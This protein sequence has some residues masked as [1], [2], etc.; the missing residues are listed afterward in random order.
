VQIQVEAV[1]QMLAGSFL[2]RPPAA[3]W[4]ELAAMLALGLA[5]VALAIR[6][7]PVWAA[8]V[9]FGLVLC[10][11]AAAATVF[12][13]AGLLIDPVGPAAATIVAANVAGL[14]SFMRT[15]ALKT[16]IQSKFERYVPPE[17]VA[18]LLREPQSLKLDGEL[19]EVTALIC[20][21]EEFSLLTEKSEP[22]A[23][24]HVLDDYFDLVTE[25]VVAHGGMVDKIV[26]DAVLAFFN[27]P[28][29]LADHSDAALRCARAIVAGTQEFRRRPEVAAMGFGRTR[30]GIEAGMAIVGDVGG[31]RRLDYTAYGAVVNKAARFQEANKTLRSS[32]CIGPAAVA[33]LKDAPPL[34]PLGRIAMR[35]MQGLCEVYEPWG[36]SV[37]EDVQAEYAEAAA[38]AERDPARARQLFVDVAARL[39]D[40]AVVAMWLERLGG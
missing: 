36:D 30:C 6:L 21:V 1:E 31:R 9:T 14:A 4:W 24:V 37:S 38:L 3:R 13:L 34:R 5:A 23:L 40:D 29:P 32:I 12:R 25:L 17:V 8:L 7:S 19:R 39:P 26:G 2:V 11:L 20:D 27:I 18:R 10:W 33:N 16:A 35:G 15:R 22:R 28:A